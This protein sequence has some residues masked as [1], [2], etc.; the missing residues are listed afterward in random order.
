MAR[1]RSPPRRRFARQDSETKVR[2]WHAGAMRIKLMELR[3]E[4]AAKMNDTAVPAPTRVKLDE[5]LRERP[6]EVHPTPRSMAA[7]GDTSWH[8]SLFGR[9]LELES[10]VKIIENRTDPCAVDY[11]SLLITLKPNDLLTSGPVDPASPCE[12]CGDE[13][14]WEMVRLRK[15]LEEGTDAKATTYMAVPENV[16][17]DT[18]CGAVEEQ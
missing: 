3:R 17:G 2:N 10:R 8:H 7:V 18:A 14:D 4:D 9:I 1:S 13:E 15:I 5:L 16:A 12:A 6:L 11:S